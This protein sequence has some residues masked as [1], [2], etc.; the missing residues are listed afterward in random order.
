[1]TTT[2][3]R[4]VLLWTGHILLA[5]LFTGAAGRLTG[6]AAVSTAYGVIATLAPAV[7]GVMCGW[8][9]RQR[10]V[11]TVGGRPRLSMAFRSRAQA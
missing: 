10:G 11:D 8:V 7:V 1:M 3:T 4:P 6:A 2:R 5:G 9:A